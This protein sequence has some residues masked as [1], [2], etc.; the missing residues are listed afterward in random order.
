MRDLTNMNQ[1]KVFSPDYVIGRVT[2][3][4]TYVIL[5]PDEDIEWVWQNNP[6]GTKTVIGYTITKKGNEIK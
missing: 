6:N 3:G 5:N 1:R 2:N 4:P